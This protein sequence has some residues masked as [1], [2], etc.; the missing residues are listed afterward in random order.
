MKTIEVCLSPELMHL[1][2][3]SDKTVVVVDILRATSCMV[4]AFAHDVECIMPFADLE[5]CKAMKA[6]GYITSGERNGEKVEGFDKGNSPFEYMDEIRGKKIAFTTTN[7]TQAISRSVGARDVV[8]GAFLNLSAVAK[9]VIDS[10]NHILVVCAGWKGKVNLEDTLFAGAL[11]SKVKDHIQSECDPAVMARHLYDAAKTNMVGF[12]KQAS[13]IQR[14]N[15]LGIHEDI[16]FCLT[17]DKYDIV[18]KLKD[19]ILGC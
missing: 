7:G 4:T 14:L 8:I 19:G 15:R 5:S 1:Y 13:H 6:K 11:V 12:L 10:P 3:V 17:E 2:D 16:V 9:Y 18:P